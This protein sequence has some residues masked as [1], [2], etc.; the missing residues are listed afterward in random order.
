[1]NIILITIDSLR[2]DHLGCYGY[3]K[4]TAPFLNSFTKES[5]CFSHAYSLGPVTQASVPCILT[6]T[7]SSRYGR[8]TNSLAD[9]RRT[10]AEAFKDN[11]YLTAGFHSN[12]YLSADLK[13][14]RGFD[15]FE[16]YA[17]SFKPLKRVIKEKGFVNAIKN[18]RPVIKK[19]INNWYYIPAEEINKDVNKFI[20]KN[21]NRTFFLWIH[22]M[23]V[24]IP[25]LSHN[26]N[27]VKNDY[28]IKL[29]RKMLENSGGLC[30]EEI[31]TLRN[32]YD[33]E[34]TYLDNHLKSLVDRLK[35][36]CL[37]D[38]SMII[39]TSDHGDE[40]YDHG[41]VS[42]SHKL[43][44]ELIRV[45]LIIHFPRGN[46]KGMFIN[47]PVSLL[48][49]IPTMTDVAGVEIKY[50]LDGINLLPIITGKENNERV[51]ISEVDT[52]MFSLRKGDWKLIY[53]DK[54]KGKELYNLK[55]DPKERLNLV[56][57][58]IGIL[59]DLE[60]H[61]IGHLSNI[62]DRDKDEAK[63]D[64]YDDHVRKRLRDLGYMD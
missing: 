39:I 57:K 63:P 14:N 21:K 64:D 56:N 53:N 38:D 48:D 4:E 23:D 37:Y 10:V 46:C 1:M 42:H 8:F 9:G 47:K 35:A 2:A 5:V 32:L 24:H 36:L 51:I 59:S 7:F 6:G 28:S 40:F 45:P 17:G 19:R 26:K 22:Y 41:G 30:P 60:R 58:E 11:G 12:P 55:D 34:I 25:Y 50:K 43:Y 54:T 52:Y 49:L 33:G 18:I 44:E 61:L 15:V 20:T 31:E 13:Y 27:E 62:P 3:H 29:F 16:D